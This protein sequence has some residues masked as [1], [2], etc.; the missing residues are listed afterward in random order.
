MK[1]VRLTAK[2]AN[3]LRELLSEGSRDHDHKMDAEILK[4]LEKA[5]DGNPAGVYVPPLESALIAAAR[6]KAVATTPGGHARASKQALA[7]GATVEQMTE[8]GVWLAR[9]RWL[10]EPLTILTVLNKWAEWYPK[11][12]AT[13]APKGIAEG[14][15]NGGK[16]TE[17]PDLGQASGGASKAPTHGRSPEGF[18]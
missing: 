18:R 12:H 1:G 4:R 13:S 2:L 7:V 17:A 3:Y 16:A 6:G 9:Q 8:V 5:S 10:T 11:A 14:L 15:G